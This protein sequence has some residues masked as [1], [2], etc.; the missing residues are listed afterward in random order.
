MLGAALPIS[1]TELLR[2]TFKECMDDDFILVAFSV[3]LSGP[4]AARYLGELTGLGAAFATAWRIL[5]WPLA[6]AMVAFAIGLLYYFGPDADQDWVWITPG[7]IF[8]T[9]LPAR[10]RRR[11]GR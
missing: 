10:S 2:R 1:L 11:G 9:I 8:A 7:A 5:Q 3:V 6:F 4:A